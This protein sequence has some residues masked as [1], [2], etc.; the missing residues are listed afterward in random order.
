MELNV[1]IQEDILITN[2]EGNFLKWNI[3]YSNKKYIVSYNIDILKYLF[4]LIFYIK[5]YIKLWNWMNRYGYRCL[6]IIKSYE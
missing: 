6:L 4:I 1:E 5:S 2:V 3:K